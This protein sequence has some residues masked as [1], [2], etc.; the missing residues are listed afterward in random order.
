MVASKALFSDF[1]NVYPDYDM[2]DPAYYATTNGSAYGFAELVGDTLGA[3]SLIM[4]ASAVL[5]TVV[6]KWSVIEPNAD[7]AVSMAAWL[8]LAG[9]GQVIGS[10]QLG[11]MGAARVVTV[12]RNIQIV[13][14]S[15]TGSTARSVVNILTA[16]NERR[17]RLVFQRQPGGAADSR[18]SG[19]RIMRRGNA[20]LLVDGIF[21]VTGMAAF[22]GD[23]QSTGYNPGVSGWRIRATGAAE[24][25]N[26]VD[27]SWLVDGSVTDQFQAIAVGPYTSLATN[28][29][30]AVLNLGAI[31]RG[32]LFQRGIVF[33]AR[34]FFDGGSE[35]A[36]PII[37]LKRRMKQ[38]GGGFSAYVTLETWDFNG[39]TDVALGSTFNVWQVYADTGSLGGH[40]DEYEYSLHFACTMGGTPTGDVVRNVYLTVTRSTK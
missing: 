31:P 7:Y 22:G 3:N 18:H 9:A 21:A 5:Q 23:L 27:R 16:A 40:Y 37:Q 38:L 25:S 33:E 36:R 8:A 12:T 34:K 10:I 14:R 30:V 11:S 17:F 4:P 29:I 32:N 19:P 20:S 1:T 15:D 2:D 28:T 13:N 26:L 6:S 24:F 39:A 35:T